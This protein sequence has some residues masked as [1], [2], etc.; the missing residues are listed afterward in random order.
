MRNK[1]VYKNLSSLKTGISC[2][3]HVETGLFSLENIFKDPRG[4][5]CEFLTNYKLYFIEIANLSCLKPFLE[6]GGIQINN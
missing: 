6:Q 5:K 2:C 3:N 1:I 4:L